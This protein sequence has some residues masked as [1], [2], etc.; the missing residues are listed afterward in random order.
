[1]KRNFY[2]FSK[3]MQ[4]TFGNKKYDKGG[5]KL[6]LNNFSFFFQLNLTF[7]CCFEL[8]DTEILFFFEN[9]NKF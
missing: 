4:T 5:Q 3:M 8:K 2:S 6:F 9:K 1:M 7:F